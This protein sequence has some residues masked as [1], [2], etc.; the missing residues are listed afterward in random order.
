MPNFNRRTTM[1]AALATAG[2]M[3]AGQ[4]LP[5]NAA[6]EVKVALDWTPNTNH[7]GLF[8]AQ[9]E[10]YFKDAGLNVKI[11]PY[12]DTSAGALVDNQV[13]DFGINGV[14]FYSQRA[15]G[16]DE[17]AVYAVVQK[18]TGRLVTLADRTDIKSPKDLDGKIYGGFGSQWESALLTTMI[19]A[20]GGEG[21]FQAVT[22][23][24]SAYQALANKNVDFTLEILTWEG[25]E[26]ALSG[27]EL[28]DFKYADYGIPEQYTTLIV[29]SDAYLKAH[30]DTTKAF[31]AAV[32]K[33]YAFAADHP[34]KASE[35]LIA[36]NP[37]ALTNKELVT[38]SM[39]L[40]SK[41]NFLRS[42]DGTIGTIEP[43]K[44][45]AVGEFLYDKG[46]LLD[47][48]GNTLTEKPDFATYFSNDYLN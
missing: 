5:A 13:A 3:L 4:V 15:A 47:K 25:V 34:D 44:M 41:E 16:A 42:A 18:E 38:K 30:A 20:D 32:K 46:M 7:V 26:A 21:D 35:I 24:T 40:L 39:E 36:A 6:E 28:K 43:T 27:V 1:I 11:L 45:I 8:V 22:L 33:G 37:D 12:T 9:E 19:K 14:G 23:G 2:L 48:D 31:L 17:V 29:S 10:G